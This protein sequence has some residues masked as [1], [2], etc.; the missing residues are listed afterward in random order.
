M[1]MLA[2]TATDA[3]GPVR[4]ALLA[5]ARADAAAEVSRAK[6]E[7]RATVQEAAG[8]ADAVRQEARVRGEA[9]AH[10][11]LVAMRARSRREARSVVLGAQSEVVV[12]LR[13]RVHAGLQG[14]RDDPAFGDM[15]SRLESQARA[16]LGPDVRLAKDPSGGFIAESGGRRAELT[17]AA[18]ADRLLDRFGP[19][20]QSLWS[21]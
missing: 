19:E 18:V 12:A 6:G 7:A 3:L 15:E 21:R 10:A 8:R 16:L 5:R 1:T 2:V 20:L 11:V 9:D 14:L 4:A 17:L 13:D